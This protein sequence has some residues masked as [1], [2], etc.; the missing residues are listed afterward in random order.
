MKRLTLEFTGDDMDA[1][2]LAAKAMDFYMALDDFDQHLRSLY[3]YQDVETVDVYEI[4]EKLWEYL[5]EHDV[6]LDMLN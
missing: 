4:R 3:K 6:S 5:R 2:M 1:G